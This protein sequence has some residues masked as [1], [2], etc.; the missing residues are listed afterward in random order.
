MSTFSSN[1]KSIVGTLAPTVAT[2]LGGPFAGAAVSALS[3]AL[4]L[5]P[6]AEPAAVESAV[7]TASTEDLAKIKVAEIDFQQ[8]LATLGVEREQLAF[9]DT[10]S[11]RKREIALKDRTPMILAFAFVGGW[12]VIQGVLLSH[13]IDPAMR[14]II[15][16]TLGTMDTALALILSYYFGSSAGADARNQAST[17]TSSAPTP[18]AKP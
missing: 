17:A 14:D 1:F 3:H 12:F 11:A 8:T 18:A 16:R 4:G 2:A 10:D 9:S 15:M 6:N 13:T 5:A 7:T